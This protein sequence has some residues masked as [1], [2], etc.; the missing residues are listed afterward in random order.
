VRLNYDLQAAYYC[1]GIRR[2]TGREATF[3][4]GASE[5]DAAHGT[6][7]YILGPEHDLMLNGQRKY[8]YALDLYARCKAQ[9]HWPAYEQTQ[10][11]SPVMEP[12]MQFHAPSLGG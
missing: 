7:H 6:R 10:P 8:R 9:G 5:A 4:F 11:V 1:E 2:F 3:V 12:W